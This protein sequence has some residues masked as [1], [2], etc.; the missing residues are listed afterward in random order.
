MSRP[1]NVASKPSETESDA[2]GIR[3]QKFL[4]AAGFGSRRACEEYITSGRVTVDGTRV[5]ELGAR[6]HPKRQT[7]RVDDEPVRRQ[8]KRYFLL[9]K[10]AGYV[11]THRDPAGRPRAVDLVGQNDLRL[12]TVGR[13]DANSQGLLLVTNDGDLGQKL[14]HPRYQVPRTYRVQVAGNPKPETLAQLKR[15]LQFEEG[16]F[17]VRDVRRLKQQGK[18]VFL[19][20]VLTEGQNREIRRLLARLGHKVIHLERIGFGPLKLGRLPVGA[21]RPLRTQELDALREYVAGRTDKPPEA[22][23]P[24]RA[25]PPGAPQ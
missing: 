4:A 6:V 11:C 12:F 5:T 10:P 25:P 2:A 3:L 7:I 20:L 19:E 21:H 15:G 17:R 24:R 1:R 14:A 8:P 9:N 16:R 23:R 18:S 22:K 13:L